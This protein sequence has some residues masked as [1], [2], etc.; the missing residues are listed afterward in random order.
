MCKWIIN[1]RLLSSI[2]LTLTFRR[3]V[4]EQ[5]LEF[6]LLLPFGITLTERSLLLLSSTFINT[7][8]C[9]VKWCVYKKYREN[10][11]VS[12]Q[13]MKGTSE[14]WKFLCCIWKK[15]ST[16]YHRVASPVQCKT[17][18]W[19][20]QVP[21]TFGMGAFI[22]LKCFSRKKKWQLCWELSWHN[23]EQ[24]FIFKDMQNRHLPDFWACLIFHELFLVSE[25]CC[26]QPASWLPLPWQNEYLD[27][28]SKLQWYS[29]SVWAPFGL[30]ALCMQSVMLNV[31][32]NKMCMSPEKQVLQ[33]LSWVWKTFFAHPWG[34]LHSSLDALSVAQ[35]CVCS[36][37]GRRCIAVISL[38]PWLVLLELVW[39]NLPNEFSPTEVKFIYAK[40]WMLSRKEFAYVGEKGIDLGDKEA[41]EV[42][43]LL[44]SLGDVYHL[45]FEYNKQDGEMGKYSKA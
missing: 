35:W 41:V 2:L 14:H 43:C 22:S 12:L 1:Y 29:G 13:T 42:L 15:N 16:L 37:L 32:P 20:C 6:Y 7:S 28:P 30:H 19:C 44:L 9:Q 36:G 39:C 10:Y 3:R 24:P 34:V 4:C 21:L 31:S 26:L 8:V 40:V 33:N 17:G 23:E 18:L 25:L 11:S 38:F 45:S 27:F 5:R